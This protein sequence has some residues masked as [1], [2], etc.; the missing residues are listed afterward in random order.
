M[1]RTTTAAL[2]WATVGLYPV[3]YAVAAPHYGD[4]GYVTYVFGLLACAFTSAWFRADA[5]AE[6]VRPPRDFDVLVFLVAPLAVPYYLLRY[7]GWRRGLMA[8]AKLLLAAAAT[9][10]LSGLLLTAV[11][12]LAGL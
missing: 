3:V 12:R 7:R 5:A 9:I 10:A 4:V 6:G 11:W 8:L 1:S 2:C